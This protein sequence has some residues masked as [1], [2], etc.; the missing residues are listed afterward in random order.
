MVNFLLVES[1]GSQNLL[2]PL[3]MKL[4]ARSLRIIDLLKSISY[5]CVRN[6]FEYVSA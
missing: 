3:G 5:H 6:H 1:L 2:E 4:T